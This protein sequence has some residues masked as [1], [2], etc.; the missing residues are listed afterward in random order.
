MIW[1]N[2]K[3]AIIDPRKYGL[4]TSCSFST[5]I[6]EESFKDS[7]RNAWVARYYIFEILIFFI[8]S[9]SFSAE[10]A[11]NFD[12][13]NGNT[14]FLEIWVA[15]MDLVCEIRFVKFRACE[16]KLAF[17]NLIIENQNLL[18]GLV[19]KDW[20]FSKAMLYKQ[21]FPNFWKDFY[22]YHTDLHLQRRTSTK[23][24]NY[25]ALDS[26]LLSKI[27]T[28]LKINYNHISRARLRRPEVLFWSV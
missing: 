2:E 9:L 20:D 27:L 6:S 15:I 26:A 21:F 16:V 17:Q 5:F 19:L 12:H 1:Y 28:I 14:I 4:F 13:S 23:V 24:H 8:S 18:R 22:M 7:T 10:D 11:A 3:T 25:Q